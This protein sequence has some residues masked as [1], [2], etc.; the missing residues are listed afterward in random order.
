MLIT[1]SLVVKSLLLV[2][3]S[4]GHL[5]LG[6][7]TTM[8]AMCQHFSRSFAHA[9]VTSFKLKKEQLFLLRFYALA[10]SGH[11]RQ[12]STMPLVTVAYLLSERHI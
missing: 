5:L 1:V 2:S 11:V 7:V 12:L 6:V 8:T 9:R 3:W 10:L 4:R